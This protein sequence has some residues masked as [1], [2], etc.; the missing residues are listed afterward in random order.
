VCRRQ[1]QRCPWRGGGSVH[2]G[3][4]A[5]CR[6]GRRQWHLSKAVGVS[7]SVGASPSGRGGGGVQAEATECAGSS[8]SLRRVR[9]LGK[10]RMDNGLIY[11]PPLVPVAATNRDKGLLW[12]FRFAHEPPPP[13]SPG[14]WL[15][16]G[17]KGIFSARQG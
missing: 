17:L 3:V 12:R 11:P 1:R 6:E 15:Q 8:S 7:V 2:E 5:V 14:W 4:T 13:F 16:P 9:R 10:K